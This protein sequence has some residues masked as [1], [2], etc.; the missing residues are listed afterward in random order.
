M[1]FIISV[2]GA[3]TGSRSVSIGGCPQRDIAIQAYRPFPPK[4]ELAA[5]SAQTAALCDPAKLTDLN[6][7]YDR[8]LANGLAQGESVLLGQYLFAVLLG[9]S[10]ALIENATPGGDVAEL[11]LEIDPSDTEM[12]SL[13]W[14][15][16]HSSKGFLANSN[17]PRVTFSRVIP[18]AGSF[19]AP[20]FKAP[21]KVLFVVGSQLNSALRP[22]LELIGL[23]RR[24]EFLNAGLAVRYLGEAEYDVFQQTVAEFRPSLVHLVCHGQIRT[25]A[26]PEI[27]LL[28]RQPDPA[29]RKRTQSYPVTADRLITL[30]QQ[31]GGWVPPIVILNA[32]YT[33]TFMSAHLSFAARLV[34]QGVAMSMGMA[35]EAADRAC[36]AFTLGF[37]QALLTNQPVTEATA[38]GRRAALLGYP[39]LEASIEWTRA[40]LFLRKGVRPNITV[41]TPANI[42]LIQRAPRLRVIGRQ[43]DALCARDPALEPYHRMAALLTG[44]RAGAA[45]PNDPLLIAFTINDA[46]GGVGKTRLLEEIAVRGITDGLFP[47]ILRKHEQSAAPSNFLDFALAVSDAMAEVRMTFDLGF[48]PPEAV[49]AALG[50]PV[51]VVTNVHK[52]AF[53]KAGIVPDCVNRTVF[54]TQLPQVRQTVAQTGPD[55]APGDVSAIIEAL[56]DDFHQLMQDAATKG[57]VPYLPLLLLDDVHLYARVALTIL[58]NI[59]AAGLG[60]EQMPI[61]LVFTYMTTTTEGDL[62][63]TALRKMNVAGECQPELTVFKENIEQRLAYGQLLL[64]WQRCT[65]NDRSK[66]VKGFLDKLQQMTE[67]R[68]K[69]VI[70]LEIEN[71]ISGA[72]FGDALVDADFD[73]IMQRYP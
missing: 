20:T 39:E 44:R 41:P 8:F 15:M 27:L 28:E 30:M 36:Q 35:G 50:Q 21:F 7:L 67:G 42:D 70:T 29:G 14:E 34:N 16:I 32:C 3:G 40:T 45:L 25:G 4:D 13:P 33:G 64:S 62:I 71:Y 47:V 26:P 73:D 68:V 72:R 63:R 23:L 37:Y 38:H 56:Q 31:P 10:W 54:R 61:P 65:P 6:A 11:E 5:Y 59:G 51:P 2:T 46:A 69:K 49:P 48:A 17:A 24:P 58:R 18:P 52:F 22:G 57:K 60:T 55:T 19:G 43:P 1:Q 9:P 53:S 12:Q 66:N